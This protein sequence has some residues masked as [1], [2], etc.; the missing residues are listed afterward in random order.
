MLHIN[1]ELHELLA[2]ARAIRFALEHNAIS[3]DGATKRVKPLLDKLNAAGAS[4]AKKYGMKYRKITF[5]N[6]GERNL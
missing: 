2:E 6:L 3:Y 4:I 1:K 5:E